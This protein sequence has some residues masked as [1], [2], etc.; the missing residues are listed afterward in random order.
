MDYLAS[1]P[2]V[3]RERIGCMGL[4]IG[5]WTATNLA[6]HQPDKIVSLTLIEPV[7]IVCIA[8]FVGFAE[9]SVP[10]ATDSFRTAF[11]HDGIDLSGVEI[12]ATAFTNLLQNWALLIIPFAFTAYGTF[13]MRQFFLGIPRDIDEAAMIDGAGHFRIFFRI[14]LPL[15]KPAIAITALFSFMTAWNEFILASVFM[16][17]EANYTAPVGLRFFVGGFSS[18]WGFFAAGSVIVSL[19]SPPIIVSAPP[20]PSSQSLPAWPLSQLAPPSPITVSSPRLALMFS[21]LTSVSVCAPSV[22]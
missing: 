1:R 3:N 17:S 21:M 6:L 18:R 12:A 22:A 10:Q 4:S 16:E 14:I 5:G 13:L 19:P 20:A 7:M 15:A 9:L 11:S 8:V 2:E